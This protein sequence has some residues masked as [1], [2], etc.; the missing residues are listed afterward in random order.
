MFICRQ[1]EEILVSDHCTHHVWAEGMSLCVL[2]LWEDSSEE[3]SH[4]DL[5]F[6]LS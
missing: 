1:E 2:H 4:L 6:H 5:A 3:D